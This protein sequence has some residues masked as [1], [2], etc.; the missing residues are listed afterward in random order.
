MA[1]HRWLLSVLGTLAFGTVTA[2]AQAYCRTTTCNA[3]TARPSDISSD[4]P[5]GR[6]TPEGV[7]AAEAV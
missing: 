3:K 5:P 7:R 4:Q 2:E 1:R 6:Q